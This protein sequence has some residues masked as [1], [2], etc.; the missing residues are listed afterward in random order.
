MDQT[1]QA[2]PVFRRFVGMTGFNRGASVLRS[3]G[4]GVTLIELMVVLTI[5]AIL[6]ALAWPSYRDSVYRSRR[7]DAMQSLVRLAQAQERWRANSPAYAEQL[8]DLNVPSASV[9]GYYTLSIQASS[10]AGYTLRATATTGAAQAGDSRCLTFQMTAA[11]GNLNYSSSG[12]AGA[13]S[14]PDPCWV[15]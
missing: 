4:R 14:S 11:G 6:A 15:K 13:N 2:R 10:A 9:N 1:L 8:T 3:P 12:S 5:G 7:S